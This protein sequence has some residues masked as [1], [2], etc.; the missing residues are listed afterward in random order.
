MINNPPTSGA[1]VD[2]RATFCHL[3]PPRLSS[4]IS[5]PVR[6]GMTL[7]KVAANRERWKLSTMSGKP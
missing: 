2:R 6:R 5:L 7:G 1:P 3:G 4:A